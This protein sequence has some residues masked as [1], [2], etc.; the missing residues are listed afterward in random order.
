L[1]APTLEGAKVKSEIEGF[2]LYLSVAESERLNM[3]GRPDFT[4]DLY[5]RYLPYAVA[6]GVEKP[7]SK[8][9]EAH[10][11][12]AMPGEVNSDTYHPPFYSGSGWSSGAAFGAGAMASTLGS[13]F[14]SAM[15]SQSSGSSGGGSSGGGGGGGGGG[16]W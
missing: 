3:N 14:A 16:G 5:E 11:A 9:L 6:L 7:W 12:T 2:K 4:I 15:P 1:F 10:L 8:A 13:S